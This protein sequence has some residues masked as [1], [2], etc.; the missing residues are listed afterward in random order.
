MYGGRWTGTM[1]L[2]EPQ[3]GSSLTDVK[4]RATPAAD[5]HYLVQGNKVFISGGDQDLT[6]NIVH[7]TLARIDGAPPGIKGVS[8]F[9]IPKKR[10]EGGKLVDNDVHCAGAFHKMG[11][12][13][14]P[15][16]A[17]NFGERGDCRGWLVG[18]PHRGI[19][20]MFQMMN[21]ARLM[22][23]MNAIATASV[24]YFESLEYA[25]TRPQ[26]RRLS[27]KDPKSPQVPII[28]HAD[29]RRMLLRQKAIVE[30]ALS[31]GVQTAR[32]ADLAAHAGTPE[33]KR[34]AFLLLD[35]MTPVVKSFPAEKGFEA[36]VL[37]VQVHGG[38]GYTSEYLPEAW[39]RDQKL[40]SIHEGTTCMHSM[41]LLGRK[42]VADQGSA[43]RILGEEIAAATKRAASAGVDS[44]WCAAVERAVG[45]GRRADHAPGRSRTRRQGGRHDA[46]QRG[47]PR[48]LL[49]GGHRL[50]VAA[51]GGRRKGRSGGRPRARR[52]LRGQDLRGG[53]LDQDGAPAH[54]ASR[55]SLPHRRGLLRQDVAGL[56]LSA[57]LPACAPKTSTPPQR[58][59]PAPP[60]R[61]ASRVRE[62]RP[63]TT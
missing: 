52:L 9:A 43:L 4:T 35:M 1:A 34:R 62:S 8:L 26:G 56:V 49:D 47:L 17:L 51:A 33:D 45:V 41:D 57:M 24:A 63:G 23:G 50:A 13:G 7:L 20:Y 38:Y 48:P 12:R 5:G 59:P 27:S 39:M 19:S 58:P 46:P 10:L 11:W 61:P 25:R 16:I 29:V 28:E 44:A 32:Y 30:G 18:E 55:A 53:V 40:N 54:G 22:V 6:E 21:E 36:N 60:S 14:V 42:V 3:A 2:T 37:A 31:L 15:S